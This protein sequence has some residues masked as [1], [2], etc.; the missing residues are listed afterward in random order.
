M[1]IPRQATLD[2]LRSVLDDRAVL[3]AADSAPF[4]MG[5]RGAPTASEAI[6]VRPPDTDGVAATVEI[7][8]RDGVCIVAQGGNTGL[9][10]GTDLAPDR[11]GIVLSLSRLNRVLSV[12]PDQWTVTAQAGANIEKVQEAARERGR[13]FAPDWGA[14]GSATVGGAIATNAGGNNVVRYGTMRNNVLGIEAVLAD[15]TVWDG[16]RALVKDATGYDLKQLF[17]GSE[18]TLGVVTSA[19]LRLHPPTP[20]VSSMLAAIPDL[21]VLAPLLEMAQNEAQERLTAFELLPDLAMDRVAELTDA[22]KPIDSG[23]EYYV[24]IKL[25]GSKPVDGEVAS[26]LSAAV[27][28]GYVVDAVIAGTPEQESNLWKLRDHASPTFLYV[29]Y[30]QHGLKLDTAVPIDRVETFVRSVSE[31]A[32]TIAPMALTYGFG[33]VGDGNLHMMILPVAD[34]AI[35]PWLTVRQAMSDEV[36]RIVFELSGTL[37]AEHGIGTLL[38]DRVRPQKPDIEWHMMRAIKNALDPDDL[39]NPGKLIPLA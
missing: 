20:H 12:D 32:A 19:V 35:E 7:C 8:A 21:D 17:I 30:Q 9:S 23:T 2:D 6:V 5:P 27:D 31:A 25:A 22:V 10:G 13:L 39:F 3:D 28:A 29:E 11:P 33:H 14:R 18:G 26:L 37:S 1:T 36:D 38:L 24:L 16:R 34:E 15:G 4:L